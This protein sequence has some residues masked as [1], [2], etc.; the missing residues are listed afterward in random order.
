MLGKMKIEKPF[1]PHGIPI[2]VGRA[3]ETKNCMVSDPIE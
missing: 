1:G 3:L 2:G